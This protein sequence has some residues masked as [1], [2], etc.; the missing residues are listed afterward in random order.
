MNTPLHIAIIM[1][2][3]GRWAEKR[4]LPRIFGHKEGINRVEE[5]IRY[6]PS[7]GVRYLTLYAFST[8]N[9]KRPKQEVDFLFSSFKKYL[10]GKRDELKENGVALR[11]IG[12]K[13]SLPHDLVDT[14]NQTEAF[15]ADGERLLLSI[16]FNYGSRY[17]I[18]NAINAILKK[19]F[20]SVDEKVFE[21]FLYTSGI[22]DPDLII[23]TSGEE[24]LSNFL[25]WQAAYSEF[26]FT[27]VLWPDFDKGCFE[28]AL[29]VYAKRKRRFGAL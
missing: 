17:E 7:L 8:E 3:N 14:I 23:R 19:G 20:D 11:I 6:A 15:L 13:E 25:L 1:D 9:W 12:H 10:I 24:R 4:G 21:K 28:E 26:Y 16:A 5:I 18:I 27:D 22:P 2:G 29:E